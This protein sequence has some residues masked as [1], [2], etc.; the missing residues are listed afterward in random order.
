[1]LQTPL[2]SVRYMDKQR[3]ANDCSVTATC[4]SVLELPALE[5]TLL[6]SIRTWAAY[7]DAPQAIWRTLEG[8]FTEAGIRPAL[9]PFAQLMCALFVGLKRYPDIRCVRCL[10]MGK[11]EN[12][13]LATLAM[14]L[15]ESPQLTER[16]LSVLMLPAEARTGASAALAMMH[17]VANAGLHLQQARTHADTDT[18]RWPPNYQSIGMTTH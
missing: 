14:A 1:M 16:R 11:D 9:E 5:R 2:I 6:W 4:S 17:S 10:R 13:L 3:Q 15:Q 8:A 18:A 7:H 12:E